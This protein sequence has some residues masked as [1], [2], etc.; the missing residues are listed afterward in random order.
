[1][2]CENSPNNVSIETNALEDI[3]FV[4]NTEKLFKPMKA[5]SVHYYECSNLIPN[6]V[7]V[8]NSYPQAVAVE[9]DKY[10]KIAISFLTRIKIC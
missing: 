7:F 4:D 5:T 3:L 10:H 2:Q 9:V 6:P 1:M 8:Y